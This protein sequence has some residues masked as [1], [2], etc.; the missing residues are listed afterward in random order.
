MSNE[1]RTI[2]CPALIVLMAVLSP[3]GL[4]QEDESRRPY[5]VA[6]LLG[7]EPS[8]SLFYADRLSAEIQRLLSEARSEHRTRV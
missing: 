8:D 6:N 1:V 3:S 5:I 4:S 2:L 7:V